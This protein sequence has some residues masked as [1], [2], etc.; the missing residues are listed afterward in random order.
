MLEQAGVGSSLSRLMVAV[1]GPTPGLKHDRTLAIFTHHLLMG[2]QSM[3]FNFIEE[4]I[5]FDFNVL[6]RT[7]SSL[8]YS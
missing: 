7:G 5:C 2:T 1:L 8:E 6:S 3:I 4:K